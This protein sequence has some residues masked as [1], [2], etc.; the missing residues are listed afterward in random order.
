VVLVGWTKFVFSA[1]SDTSPILPLHLPGWQMNNE[2]VFLLS[3]H[4]MA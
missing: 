2:I 3:S 1:E 4:V